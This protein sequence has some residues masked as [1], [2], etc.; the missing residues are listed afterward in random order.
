[1]FLSS[2]LRGGF[3]GSDI[4][5]NLR[6]GWDYNTVYLI[7]HVEKKVRDKKTYKTEEQVISICSIFLHDVNLLLT[8]FNNYV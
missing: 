6:I 4:K 5:L 3:L 8:Y 1:M 2:G 7:I